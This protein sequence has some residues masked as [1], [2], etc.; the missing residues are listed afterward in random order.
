LVYE[1]NT[2]S[3]KIWDS[4]GFK[5]IG[6]VPGCGLLKS[7]DEPIDAIIYGRDLKAEGE[8]VANE[9]R[10]DKIRYYLR[11]SSYP[12][13][14]G[15]SEKSRLRSAATHY[16]LIGG[17]DGTPE[18]LMLKDKEVISDPQAQYDIA[19]QIHD[20]AHGG[21][22]KTTA[23][24]ATKYHWVRI[25][26]TVSHVIKNCVECKE[27]VKSGTTRADSTRSNRNK[28]TDE[29]TPTPAPPNS[30]G[31]LQ[32]THS[33]SPPAMPDLKTHNG[34]QDHNDMQNHNDMDGHNDL[35]PHTDMPPHNDLH[36][37]NG[38]QT[39]H[40][41]AHDFSSMDAHLGLSGDPSM[42]D[43]GPDLPPF[44]DMA[45]DPT[46]LAQL[47]AQ[48]ASDGYG[49]QDPQGHHHHDFVNVPPGLVDYVDATTLQQQ[50]P[51]DQVHGF[52]GR[53][54]HQHQHSHHDQSGYATQSGFNGHPVSDPQ[55]GYNGHSMSD[56]Q[57]AYNQHS[58]SDPQ[59]QFA[60]HDPTQAIMSDHV[61]D[62]GTDGTGLNNMQ[63]MQNVLHMDYISS[64]GTEFKG[65]GYNKQ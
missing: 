12:Q 26:E 9:E 41:Q 64:D 36:P 62:D 27:S 39:S 7:F 5:R 53:H 28:S 25:K 43:D 35:S 31:S 50:Q 51:Q 49:H 17:D 44:D 38:M 13:G 20:I 19:K 14:A 24:I 3:T 42:H 60:M 61:M 57:Q 37:H 8:N 65:G 54:T 58:V 30:A 47:Q 33:D 52:N 18:K 45:I 15:R 21:I 4:L 59:Q 34:M 6:R 32:A 23:I 2:A 10:F 16:K 48:M 63:P 22:N 55:Q 1:T 46:I 29:T 56:P 11:H 40:L